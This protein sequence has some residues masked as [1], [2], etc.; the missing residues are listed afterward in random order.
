MINNIFRGTDHLDNNLPQLFVQFEEWLKGPDEG[1]KNERCASQ[2]HSRVQLVINVIDPEN[3]N[4]SSLFEKK[5]LRVKW[6]NIFDEEKQPGTVK[7]YLDALNKFYFFLKCEGVE[8]HVP[9]AT[10]SSLSDQAKSY[11][12]QVMQKA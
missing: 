12:D 9:L 1:R 10:L 3:P 8:V 5:I 7:S 6:L 2:C 4:L 11:M